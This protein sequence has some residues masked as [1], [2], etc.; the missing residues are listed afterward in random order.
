M[1]HL[2]H[3]SARNEAGNVI[4][5]IL[6]A[7]ALF[8]AL[9]FTLSR[10]MQGGNSDELNA[11]QLQQYTSEILT[12]AAVAENVVNQMAFDGTAIDEIDP[13]LPSDG[14]FNTAPNIKKLFHVSGGGLNYKPAKEP[15]FALVSPA[16][17]TQSA[18]VVSNVTNVEWT[19]STAN[20]IILTAFGI[21]EGICAEINKKLTG[22]TVIPTLNSP[23]LENDVFAENAGGSDLTTVACAGCE[24]YSS[25]CV[26]RVDP[27]NRW[28]FYSIIAAN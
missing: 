18:W 26:S 10:S 12:Y 8:G 11:A 6:I 5:L 7:V 28:F 21:E 17:T 2:H 16:P 23:G 25:I 15:P 22:S 20:D 24:G 3:H 19:P 13:I 27:I 14:A 1:K 9:T 4:V